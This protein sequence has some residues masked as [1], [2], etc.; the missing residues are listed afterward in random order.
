M[1]KREGSKINQG[2]S[3]EAQHL[4]EKPLQDRVFKE[5]EPESEKKKKDG[6]GE[7]A[8]SRVVNGGGEGQE[9]RTIPKQGQGRGARKKK[10]G[11]KKKTG[12]GTR[13]VLQ[14]RMNGW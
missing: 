9:L 2:H 4:E 5:G 1:N 11:V 6:G 14:Q 13:A 10:K 12:Q 7:T 8:K 3:A